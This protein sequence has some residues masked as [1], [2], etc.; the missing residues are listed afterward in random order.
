MAKWTLWLVMLCSTLKAQD[1]RFP[2]P[3]YDMTLHVDSATKILKVRTV[4]T[5]RVNALPSGDT[6]WFRLPAAGYSAADASKSREMLKAGNTAMY[7]AGPAGYARIDSLSVT[8]DKNP[9]EHFSADEYNEYIGIKKAGI[10]AEEGVISFTYQIRIPV[11]V[12][13]FGRQ[14]DKTIVRDFYPQL[15]PFENGKWDLS[16]QWNTENKRYFKADIHAEIH[17][18]DTLNLYTNGEHRTAEDKRTHIVT[19][20]GMTDLVLIFSSVKWPSE[21]GKMQLSKGREVPFTIWHPDGKIPQSSTAILNRY[22]AVLDTLI[23]PYPYQSLK[24]IIDR[25]LS[26]DGA[27]N[28]AVIR[29]IKKDKEEQI[30]HRTL[31][32]IWVRG[33]FEP[34]RQVDP[35]ITRWVAAYYN[36]LS[37]KNEEFAAPANIAIKNRI[38]SKYLNFEE[39]DHTSEKSIGGSLKLDRFLAIRK[40]EFARLYSGDRFAEVLDRMADEKTP[41]STENLVSGLL[42]TTGKDTAVI[43]NNVSQHSY[44]DY[45]IREVKA[46]P[47]GIRIWIE[48]SEEGT[49]PFPV[50]VIYKDGSNHTVVNDG[51]SGTGVVDLKDINLNSVESIRIDRQGILYETNYCNNTYYVASDRIGPP[52]KLS[53]FKAPDAQCQ[54]NLVLSPLVLY[55][56]NDRIMPAFLLTNHTKPRTGP[57]VYTLM[58]AF[59]VKNKKL[60]GEGKINY[61]KILAGSIV[62]K[63]NIGTGIRSFDFNSNDKWGYSQRYVRFDPG[64]TL[65]MKSKDFNSHRSMLMVKAYLVNEEYPVFSAQGEFDKLK[66]EWSKIYRISYLNARRTIFNSLNFRTD[67][68]QQSYTSIDKKNNY[69]KLTQTIN[70]IWQYDHKRNIGVRIFAA[71]FISNTTRKSASYQNIFSRGSIALIHQGFNDYTYQDYYFSRQNQTRLYDNQ[72]SL[73]DGGGFKTPLGSASGYGMSN[74]WAASLNFTADPFLLPPWLPI[75]LYFDVGTFSTHNSGAEKFSN[76]FLYNG[77]IL[78]N[79]RNRVQVHIPLVYSRDLGNAYKEGHRN[80]WSRISFGINLHGC[81]S[82]PGK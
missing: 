77:G 44:T 1:L 73:Q 21:V 9:A 78:I 7:F 81:D 6:I 80:F 58:P 4:M 52:L 35:Y 49:S 38:R 79:F 74:N 66:G 61:E 65:E 53:F 64:I 46:V 43:K 47:G 11:Y 42:S 45:A 26:D 51:F 14:K 22:A 16:Y 19:G 15:A 82:Y 57:L 20:S 41:L 71:G 54:K 69:L 18:G 63:I 12:Q 36:K 17:T 2:A 39:K 56:D 72:V 27:D 3:A 33:N 25:D 5:F 24:I 67:L 37:A 8:W 75:K 68:E 70:Y 10:H 29:R 13:G 76:N 23:G 30:L 28:L 31:S 32:R 59:S 55:N 50:T 34:S 48:N 60:V 40:L 62:Q